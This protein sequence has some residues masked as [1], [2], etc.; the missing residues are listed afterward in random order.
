MKT[1]IHLKIKGTVIFTFTRS[2]HSFRWS[3]VLC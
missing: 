2:M 3:R 1:L